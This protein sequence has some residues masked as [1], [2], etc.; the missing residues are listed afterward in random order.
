[1]NKK[2]NIIKAIFSPYWTFFKIYFLKRGFLDGVEGFVIA[3]LYA[4]YTF[5]KYIKGLR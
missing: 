2:F 3:K 4:Q 5:W 1:M